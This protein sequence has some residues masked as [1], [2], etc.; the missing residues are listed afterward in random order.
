MCP[1]P[2][3]GRVYEE[4]L[5]TPRCEADPVYLVVLTDSQDSPPLI[6]MTQYSSCQAQTLLGE[7]SRAVQCQTVEWQPWQQASISH[8]QGQVLCSI[9]MRR[10]VRCS[11]P[12]ISP[13]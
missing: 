13:T 8:P 9:V 4:I 6:W 12:A 5:P 3:Q 2:A 7:Q 11:P 10:L 1:G